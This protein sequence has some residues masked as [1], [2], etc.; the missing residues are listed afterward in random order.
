MRTSPIQGRVVSRY[1]VDSVAFAQALAA[2][3]QGVHTNEAFA[4]TLFERGTILQL[5]AP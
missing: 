3:F 4:M 5:T 1:M 2:L